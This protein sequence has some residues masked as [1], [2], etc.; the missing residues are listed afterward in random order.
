M[1][2]A[3]CNGA[4]SSSWVLIASKGIG[5]IR[6]CRL[7]ISVERLQWHSLLKVKQ[8]QKYFWGE[9][10]SFEASPLLVC[11]RAQGDAFRSR[12]WWSIGS[13]K[14]TFL[15][16]AEYQSKGAFLR[17]LPPTLGPAERPLLTPPIH[18]QVASITRVTQWLT[19]NY[20]IISE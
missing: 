13:Q 5:F 12:A 14:S 18:V 7:H 8:N 19:V 17:A 6:E 20:D 11:T 10:R 9:A 4:D 3:V 15:S 16:W 2:N 1:N